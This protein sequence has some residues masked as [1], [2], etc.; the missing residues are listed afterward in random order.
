MGRSTKEDNLCKMMPDAVL[1]EGCAW[2]HK[3]GKGQWEWAVR[4]GR[5]DPGGRTEQMLAHQH[6]AI[7]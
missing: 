4:T 1:K 2:A 3:P 7:R 6:G 5:K